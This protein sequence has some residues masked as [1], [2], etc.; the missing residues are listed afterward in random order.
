MFNLQAVLIFSCATLALAVIYNEDVE[1]EIDLTT[2]L[3]RIKE[4]I[5]FRN[6]YKGNIATYSYILQDPY[7]THVEFF[8]DDK[9]LQYEIVLPRNETFREFVVKLSHP[10]KSNKFSRIIVHKVRVGHVKLLNVVRNRGENQ[11]FQYEDN[12]YFYSKYWTKKFNCVLSVKNEVL[13]ITEKF[14]QNDEN[15]TYRVIEIKPF[16]S[17]FFKIIYVNNVPMY[18]VNSLERTIDVSHYGKIF[19]ED[20]VNISNAGN[21]QNSYFINFPPFW[22]LIA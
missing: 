20:K 2:Q 21:Y 9:E 22:Q 7:N 15:I 19:V 6:G 18:V 14:H 8:Q 13:E 12:I 5:K 17:K 16:S 4:V 10:V 1:R 3:A 11:I